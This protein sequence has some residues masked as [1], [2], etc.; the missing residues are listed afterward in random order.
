MLTCSNSSTHLMKISLLCNAKQP[1]ENIVYYLDNHPAIKS[2]QDWMYDN[3]WVKTLVLGPWWKK[4]KK[5]KI[6]YIKDKY[7]D[8]LFS[9]LLWSRQF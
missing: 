1:I 3:F 2:G 9:G 8:L 7:K 6:I 4:K 5:K